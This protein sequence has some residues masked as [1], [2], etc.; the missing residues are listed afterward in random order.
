MKPHIS[1]VGEINKALAKYGKM[2]DGKP[3]FRVIWAD[4]LTEMRVGIFNEFYGSVF[5]R[6]SKGVQ[7]V[8]K[9][10]YI[11]ERWVLERYSPNPNPEVL[12][13]DNYEPVY[14]FRDKDGN[15]LPPLLK[16]CTIIIDGIINPKRLTPQQEL[17]LHEA[18][19]RKKED[20]D[21][22]R[23]EEHRPNFM[24]LKELGELVQV[25]SKKF[26]RR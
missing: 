18:M 16:I 1:E 7:Q 8:P 15:Y 22:M 4:D 23:L 20:E 11:K 10:S 14:C 6:Q 21:V 13:Y 3:I 5:L 9:Y 17:E 12:N 25:P 24:V 26:K 2:L 19:L